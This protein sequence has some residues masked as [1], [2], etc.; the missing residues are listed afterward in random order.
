M[1]TLDDYINKVQTL[2]PAPRVLAELMPLLK[3]D[4]VDSG[5]IVQL[6]T[7]DPALTAKVLQ[8][9]NS[10][11][12]CSGRPVTDLEEAVMR[13][14]FN[15]IYRLVALTLGE[16]MFS[17]AQRGYGIAAGELWQHSVTAA[18]AARVVA[19]QQGAEENV[20]FT[21]G[22]LHDIGKLVL[23]TLLEGA[24]DKI[25]QE[26]SAAGSSFL[27]AEK[28]ILGVEHAEIGGRVLAR[29]KFPENLVAAVRHHHNPS[30]AGENYPLAAYVHVGDIIAH[31]LGQAQGLQSFAVRAHPEAMELLEVGPREL[32]ILIVEAD[33]ALKESGFASQTHS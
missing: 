2:P 33:A 4:D 24:Y 10:A 20:A 30:Q 3:E 18:L 27:E 23:S 26:I 25:L 29:W 8:R 31:C 1:Q 21:A 9:C 32:E 17:A 13:V 7:F 5:K 14:G 11:A 28:S 22:L 12:S 6:I 19:R 15:H 16:G